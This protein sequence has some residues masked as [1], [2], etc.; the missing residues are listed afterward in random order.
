MQPGTVV[1]EKYRVERVIGR[2]GMGFVVEAT[3]LHLGT[4]VAL[5]FLTADMAADQTIVAR[6]NREA[7]ASAQLKSEHICKVSDFGVDKAGPYMVMELMTGSDLA[8]L[9][10]SR[11][12]EAFTAALYIRQACVGLAEAHAAG[13]I[14]RD[15][16]PGNLFLVRRPDG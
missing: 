12:L 4:H 13:I 3:H 10:K 16:K 2:G 11:A 1:A 15:L 5:K 7:R 6:F 9:S 8:R 14:H